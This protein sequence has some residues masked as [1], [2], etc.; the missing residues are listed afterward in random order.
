[1]A[2]QNGLWSSGDVAVN[3]RRAVKED[4]GTQAN[5][6][7]AIGQAKRYPLGD[8]FMKD[9]D[10][11]YPTKDG[12][13]IEGRNGGKLCIY[14]SGAITIGGPKAKLRETIEMVR[15]WTVESANPPSSQRKAKKAKR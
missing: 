11:Y 15:E 12:G 7:W 5:L 1:M 14:H 9:P 2:A 13:N 4:H 6:N 8:P 10:Q 3:V